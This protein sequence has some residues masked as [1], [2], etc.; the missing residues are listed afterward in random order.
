MRFSPVSVPKTGP[1]GSYKKGA[2]DMPIIRFNS[3]ELGEKEVDL[4]KLIMGFADKDREGADR[5]IDALSSMQAVQIIVPEERE[6][7]FAEKIKQ[8][9]GQ[10]S[11]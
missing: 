7:E 8:L 9:G 3:W 1:R 4:R 10:I 2:Q 11:N 5:D 6:A